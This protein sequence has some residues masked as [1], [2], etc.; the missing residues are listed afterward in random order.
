M[1]L[2]IFGATGKAGKLLVEQALA[3]GNEVVIYVRNPARQA[4]VIY[5]SFRISSTEGKLPS[6]R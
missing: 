1:K 4:G 5:D 3:A 2:V 6:A